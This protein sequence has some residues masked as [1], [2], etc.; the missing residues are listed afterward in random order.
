MRYGDFLKK[1]SVIGIVAP[2]RG[3][4]T[5]PFVSRINNAKKKF[6]NLGYKV[7]ESEY[8][9]QNIKNRSALADARA[10]DFYNMYINPNIDMLLSNAGGDFCMEILPHMDFDKI[11]KSQPK[12]FQGFSDNTVLTYMLTLH[13]DLATI[14]GVCYPNFGAR[15]WDRTL[16]DNF[17]FLTGNNKQ[18]HNC[19]LYEKNNIL[20]LSSD[21]LMG[22]N[23]TEPVEWKILNGGQR[24]NISGRLI[25]GC[26][27]VLRNLVGTQY[28]I[29]TKFI[30]KYK[31]DGFIWYLETLRLNPVE[32]YL[33]LTQ[34]KMAGW[35]KY[36]KGFIFGRMGRP[37]ELN[38]MNHYDSIMD[39]LSEYNVPII[40]DMDFGHVP[41]LMHIVNGAIGHVDVVG[42]K[43]KISYELI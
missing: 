5:E 17:D 16:K 18:L 19:K 1:N 39:A 3:A 34:F 43:G 38:D 23:L 4:V 35:F 21:K 28:D 32:L 14:Y 25:G 41:P 11:S 33:T 20:K 42:S 22:Y 2:S 30:E 26:I 6:T 15:V 36:V 7:V 10:Q 27:D 31:N 8:V 9:R 29:T 40:A 37:G 13:C 12:L 24:V